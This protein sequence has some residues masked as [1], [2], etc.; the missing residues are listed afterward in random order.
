[1]MDQLAAGSTDVAA[2]PR[3]RVAVS[4]FR[5]WLYLI[6][7]SFQRQ[8]RTRQMI[9]IALALLG[10]SLMIIALTSA[11]G[12]WSMTHWHAPPPY[13][14]EYELW[15][16]GSSAATQ[17]V[18]AANPL[19]A[20]LSQSLLAVHY[21]VMENTGF[22]VFSRAVVYSFFLSFLLPIWSLSFSTE[23]LGGDRES[24]NL[25]WLLTR[26][27]SRPGIYLAKFFA[28]LPWTFAFNLGGFGLMCLVAGPGGRIAFWRYWP[29][30]LAAT[31]AFSSLFYLFST[32]FRRPAVI[33]IV[34][35]F[36][37][38][39]FVG[40][41]PGTMKRLSVGFYARCLMYDSA[42]ELGVAPPLSDSAFEPVPTTTAWAAL[43]L[44]SVVCVLIGMLVFSRSE[45]KAET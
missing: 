17:R 27:I 7:F 8:A 39:I 26:P 14:P 30:V 35:C 37:L 25:I 2:S 24:G 15:L 28:F 11:A 38:E 20:G 45:P 13:G 29:A 12:N 4:A 16:A 43:I 44:G 10:F 32:C 23:A 19:A 33:A 5:A 42:K 21:A 6:L 1:M 18:T 34:Y 31:L 41:M 22:M 3:R 9:W 40:S 36:F